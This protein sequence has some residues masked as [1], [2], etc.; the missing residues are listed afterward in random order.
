MPSNSKTTWVCYGCKTNKVPVSLVNTE[1]KISNSETG[2]ATTCTFQQC[3]T[4]DRS[5]TGLNT[6]ND[7]ECEITGKFDVESER[8]KEFKRLD[9]NDFST[10]LSPEGWLDCTIIQNAHVKLKQ[11][12][13]TGACEEL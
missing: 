8:L 11:A 6:F 2:T 1:Q 10:I 7:D 13:N 12:T 4:T 9:E 5:D 3:N